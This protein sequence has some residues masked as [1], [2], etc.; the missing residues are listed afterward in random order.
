MNHNSE[1]TSRIKT[2]DLLAE[3]LKSLEGSQVSGG[4][5]MNQF[6]RRSY[7]GVLLILSLLAMVPGISVFAVVAMIEPAFQL[8]MGLPAPV[9]PGFIQSRQVGVS[10]LQKWG[11]TISH[12]IKRLE[13]LVVPRWPSLSNDL[14]RRVIGLVVL[15]LG[16]VVAIPFPFSNFPPALA[17]ICFAL[18]LLERDG[19]MI[20]I[21]SVLSIIAFTIGFTVFYIVLSWLGSFFGI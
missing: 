18:G 13:T 10:G 17:T 7:G 9:F 11:M 20:L 19:L 8:F 6:Q 12:G 16:F 3:T 21:A 4:D 1:D 14:A 15:L 5:L 2:S